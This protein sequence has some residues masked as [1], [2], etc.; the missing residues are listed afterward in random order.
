MLAR[1]RS[2]RVIK[3]PQRFGYAYLIPFTLISTSNILNEEPKDYKEDTGIQNKK[4][5]MKSIDDEI[6]SLHDNHA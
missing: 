3:P 2:R 4:E 6:K 1:D 5:K